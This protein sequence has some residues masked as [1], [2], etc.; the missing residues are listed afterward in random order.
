MTPAHLYGIIQLHRDFVSALNRFA[1]IEAKMI[2]RKE[3]LDVKLHKIRN[4]AED[5]MS[6]RKRRR[7]GSSVSLR[8]TNGL[9]GE[10]ELLEGVEC[11]EQV[12]VDG[13]N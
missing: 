9:P 5:A 10:E 8:R 7:P 3:V 13:A 12:A 1:E 2:Q 4:N 11:D 6:S